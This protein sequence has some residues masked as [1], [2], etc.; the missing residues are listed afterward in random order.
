MADLTPDQIAIQ[1]VQAA[2]EGYIHRSLVGV[3][4]FANVL[5]GGNPDETISSRSQRAAQRGDFVGKVMCWWLD[6]IQSQHGEK[7]QA[8][9]IERAIAVEKIEEKSLGQS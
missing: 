1:E 5:L 2:K 7:A 9:D 8:G 4:Q 3:D 6:K